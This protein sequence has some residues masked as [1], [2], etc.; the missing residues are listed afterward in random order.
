MCA[1]AGYFALDI[2]FV[3]SVKRDSSSDNDLKMLV[4]W[5][6]LC[7]NQVGWI[8]NEYEADREATNTRNNL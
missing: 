1:I 6:Y 5:F 4:Q 3:G 7:F 2:Q 8:L